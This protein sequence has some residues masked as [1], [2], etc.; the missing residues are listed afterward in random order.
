MP[1]DDT[2]GDAITFIQNVL[3]LALGVDQLLGALAGGAP[4]GRG[5]GAAGG[6]TANRGQRG[7]KKQLSLRH[8]GQVASDY[9][10]LVTQGAGKY[11]VIFTDKVI[12]RLRA[13]GVLVN[14]KNRVPFRSGNLEASAYIRKAGPNALQIGFAA[15]Y[16]KY[17]RFK[18][19]RRGQRSIFGALR[20]FTRSK[21]FTSAITQ[22]RRE[23]QIIIARENE[24]GR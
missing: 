7:I 17:V 12:A 18:T 1:S 4:R 20:Q 14:V 11:A 10:L 9:I 2:T 13:A 6:R 15:D 23:T 8:S 24:R 22:A 3:F 21:V 19:P 16:A 5:L